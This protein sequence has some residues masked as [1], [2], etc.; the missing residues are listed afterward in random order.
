MRRKRRGDY[1][2]WSLTIEAALSVGAVVEAGSSEEKP[3]VFYLP[4]TDDTYYTRLFHPMK[5]EVYDSMIVDKDVAANYD[6]DDSEGNPKSEKSRKRPREPLF[7]LDAEQSKFLKEITPPPSLKSLNP[8]NSNIEVSDGNITDDG[9]KD[10]NGQTPLRRAPQKWTTQEKRIFLETLEKNGRNWALLSE[11]IGT[12]KISQI[13]N[14]YYDYKKQ[15]GRG[16]RP[17]QD[18]R[19]SSREDDAMTPPPPEQMET[20][21]ETPSELQHGYETA[22]STESGL[23]HFP[24]HN[25][26]SHQAQHAQHYQAHPIQHQGH[27]QHMHHPQYHP[28]GAGSSGIP[29]SMVHTLQPNDSDRSIPHSEASTPDRMDIWAQARRLQSEEAARRML[30][31]Q[32]QQQ[33]SQQTQQQQILSNLIPWINSGQLSHVAANNIQD[34]QL[35]NFL[36][37]QQQQQQPQSHYNH[38]AALGLS[39]LSSLASAGIAGLAQQSQPHHH[40][41]HHKPQQHH[42]GHPHHSQQQQH[43]SNT[44]H[45]RQSSHDAQLALAQ[46]LLSMQAQGNGSTSTVDALGLLARALPDPNIRNNNNNPGNN[47]Q[48]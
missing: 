36:Q 30:L 12:K 37:L 1:N 25:Y 7:T 31:Q 22:A 28:M 35:Q 19:P 16:G 13:K 4:E 29:H 42:V 39:G 10:G 8:S 24:A 6:E 18:D 14:Y 2:V 33:H 43:N 45:H 46:H 34:Q 27:P 17:D 41:S 20:V 21:E 44:G 48:G 23:S 15:A 5:R 26:Q 47:Y 3:V 38:L 40:H 11:A 32:Q 9:T